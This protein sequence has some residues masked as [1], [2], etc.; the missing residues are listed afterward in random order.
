M[1]TAYHFFNLLFS[2]MALW[3]NIHTAIIINIYTLLFAYFMSCGE[4]W[5]WIM[6]TTTMATSVVFQPILD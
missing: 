4:V 2:Y 3:F 6:Y 5:H 1:N